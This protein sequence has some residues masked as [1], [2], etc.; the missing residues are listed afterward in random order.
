MFSSIIDIHE[1]LGPAIPT[2]EVELCGLGLEKMSRHR[3]R[4]APSDLRS[5]LASGAGQS[6]DASL[7]PSPSEASSRVLAGVPHAAALWLRLLGLHP[8][9]FGMAF[10][11]YIA[12]SRSRSAHYSP[13]LVLFPRAAR[14]HHD[15][16]PR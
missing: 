5:M 3:Y 9:G 12:D 8:P 14:P 16:I 13:P 7:S 11:S 6:G 2:P 4:R 15:Y 10:A 1:P